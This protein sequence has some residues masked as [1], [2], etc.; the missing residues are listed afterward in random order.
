MHPHHTTTSDSS[1]EHTLESIA[2]S[3]ILGVLNRNPDRLSGMQFISRIHSIRGAYRNDFVAYIF[4]RY[5]MT[6]GKTP[7]GVPGCDRVGQFMNRLRTEKS[8]QG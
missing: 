4:T 2:E 7:E 8:L 6:T 5:R 3:C 1:I